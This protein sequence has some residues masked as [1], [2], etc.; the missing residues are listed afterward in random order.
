MSP[1]QE[2][3]KGKICIVTGANSGIG[4]YTCIELAQKGATIVMLCRNKEKGEKTKKEII[5]ASGNEK[6]DLMLCDLSK[7]SDIRQFAETFKSKYPALHVLIN[8]AGIIQTKRVMTDDGFESTFA[9]NYLA[10]FLL[11][12]LLLDK[13]KSGSPS[14]IINLTLSYSN[15][16]LDLDDLQFENEFSGLVAYGG[17]KITVK[18]F[19]IE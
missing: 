19:N 16:S 11:S 2:I 1:K 15:F 10:P 7:L 5:D 13:L 8:N 4:K 17:S 12:H 6:V 9:V 14:R 18:C 3:L